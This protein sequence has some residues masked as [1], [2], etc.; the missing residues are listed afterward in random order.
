MREIKPL[1]LSGL[2]LSKE[3]LASA[4]AIDWDRVLLDVGTPPCDKC[5]Y[6]DRISCCGCR[7]QLEYEKKFKYAKSVNKDDV[8][9]AYIQ[10]L[11][12]A[13]NFDKQVQ[14]LKDWIRVISDLNHVPYNVILEHLNKDMDDGWSSVILRAVLE[15]LGIKDKSWYYR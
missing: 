9:Q 7:D 5:S 11:S 3:V 14:E 10:V 1:N 8:S 4:E 12:I 13:R 15:N 6:I 2:P